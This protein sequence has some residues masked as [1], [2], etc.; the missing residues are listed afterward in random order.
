MLAIS[1][2]NF[3]L[4]K[5]RKYLHHFICCFVGMLTI[6]DFI[7]ILQKYYKAPNVSRVKIFSNAA[8]FCVFKRLIFF[9]SSAHCKPLTAHFV[10]LICALSFRKYGFFLH[11]TAWDS[12]GVIF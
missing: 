2:I 7:K 9:C 8:L 5:I 6:T 12:L 4:L 10:L 1:V 11:Y 3:S